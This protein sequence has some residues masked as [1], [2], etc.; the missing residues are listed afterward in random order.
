MGQYF[1]VFIS[2]QMD[3]FAVRKVY[4]TTCNGL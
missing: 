2:Q 1:P 4:F 3:R